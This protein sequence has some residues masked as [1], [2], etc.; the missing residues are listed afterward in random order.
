MFLNIYREMNKLIEESNEIENK[1][2]G[3]EGDRI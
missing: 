3:G 1:R 2:D